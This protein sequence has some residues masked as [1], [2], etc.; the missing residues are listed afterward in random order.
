MAQPRVL[1]ILPP[2]IMPE[3]LCIRL[4]SHP[5]GAALNDQPSDRISKPH[6]HRL[7]Q[8]GQGGAAEPFV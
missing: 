6:R 1:L 8:G 2:Q 4:H 5:N 3:I 7:C